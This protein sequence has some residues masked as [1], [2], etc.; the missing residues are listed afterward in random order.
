MEQIDL[1]AFFKKYPDAPALLFDLSWSLLEPEDYFA[2][3]ELPTHILE[4]PDFSVPIK[5]IRPEARDFLFQL[6]SKAETETETDAVL[7]FLETVW[8]IDVSYAGISSISPDDPCVNKCK[9]PNDK[10]PIILINPISSSAKLSDYFS[11]PNGMSLAESFKGRAIDTNFRRYVML[12]EWGHVLQADYMGNEIGNSFGDEKCRAEA[13]AD[14]YALKTLRKLGYDPDITDVICTFRNYR[15]AYNLDFFSAI[16]FGARNDHEMALI[17]DAELNDQTSVS[18]KENTAACHVLKTFLVQ[19]GAAE[20]TLPDDI[21]TAMWTGQSQPGRYE[22]Y[23]EHQAA[24]ITRV[25]DLLKRFHNSQLQEI[26]EFTATFVGNDI[27]EIEDVD[28]TDMRKKQEITADSAE[29]KRIAHLAKRRA[30]L[31]FDSYDKLRG[32]KPVITTYEL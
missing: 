4:R 15:L 20:E 3:L 29:V 19:H 22:E 13:D 17:L 26:A 30:E 6:Y 31:L 16:S 2:S 27:L 9:N 23:Q 7:D 10:S 8:G 28:I 1:A 24:E 14:A 18:E 32:I 12:H 25:Y 21:F 5:F 11:V